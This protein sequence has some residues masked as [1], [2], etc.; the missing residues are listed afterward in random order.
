MFVTY[1]PDPHQQGPQSSPQYPSP[2][3]IGY[4]QQAPQGTPTNYHPYPPPP[5]YPIP[6][7]QPAS[8]AKGYLIWAGAIGIAF[9]AI[10]FL[11]VLLILISDPEIS[12]IGETRDTSGVIFLLSFGYA[13]GALILGIVVGAVIKLIINASRRQPR[14]IAPQQTPTQYQHPQNRS[15]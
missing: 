15:F 9:A 6:A 2:A 11:I 10:T 12:A 5:G 7:H 13:V 4:P 14:P 8:Q 3:P 1:Q